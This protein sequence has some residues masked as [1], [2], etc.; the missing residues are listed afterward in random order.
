MR[1]RLVSEQARQQKDTIRIKRCEGYLFQ[2]R[3]E[4]EA[5]KKDLE[6]QYPQYFQLKYEI[7]VPKIEDIQAKLSE[8][9]VLVEYFF[10]K[11]HYY[12]F[13]I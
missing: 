1:Q 12:I 9:A 8:D 13:A 5:L 2:K 10:G 7:E 3:N 4:I 11:A 6:Q